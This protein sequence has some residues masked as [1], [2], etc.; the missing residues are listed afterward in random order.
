MGQGRGRERA[1][2]PPRARMG[3]HAGRLVHHEDVRILEDDAQRDG[4]GRDPVPGRRR[5]GDLH[6]LARLHAVRR[7]DL[8]AVDACPAPG[9]EGLHA[10]ARQLREAPGQPP[11][12]PRP[13]GI[14]L[15]HLGEATIVDHVA[16]PAIRRL[17]WTTRAR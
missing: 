6:A 4:L 17:S 12:E 11:I 7:L 8:A 14:G 16:A 9:D 10:H 15:H 3:H 2:D 13:G 1:V 5:D